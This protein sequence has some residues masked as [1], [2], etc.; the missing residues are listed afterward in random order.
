[1]MALHCW[2]FL[3][4]KMFF[5]INNVFLM[6]A[7]GALNCENFF[8]LTKLFEREL[9]KLAAVQVESLGKPEAE[10]VTIC[11]SLD[12]CIITVH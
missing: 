11:K 12:R 3:H 2:N 9:A 7:S 8:H 4:L 10:E 5:E 1:M 6:G